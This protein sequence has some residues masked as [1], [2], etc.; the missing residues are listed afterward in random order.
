MTSPLFE[1]VPNFS[2]GRDLDSISALESALASVP[3]IAMLDRTSDWDHHRTV[4]T[5]AGSAEAVLEA[6]VRA[7]RQAAASIDLNQH[8]GIHPR[9][10]ALDV[11][12]FI[13]LEGVTLEDCA[14]LAHRAGKRIWEEIGV[15]VYFYGAAALRPERS[16]LENVRRGQFERLRQAGLSDVT[17]APDVGGPTLHPT[18]GAVIAGA[19]K[20]LVAFNVNLASQ[21]I[22]VA[23]AI[24]KRI[25]SSNGGFPYVKALGLRLESRDL[26]QVSMNLT[27]FEVTPLD[28]VYSEVERLAA[29]YGVEIAES[30][31]IGL[32][33][34]KAVQRDFTRRFK[35]PESSRDKTI[36][37]RLG[38]AALQR[39]ASPPLL[40]GAE[41][42]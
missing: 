2:E 3:G 40:E 32:L 29:E 16:L 7:S 15:P 37:E 17:K 12:P 22:D 20:I 35:L 11:L 4:I 6:A 31:L 18:A 39:T 24:A 5:F 14:A 8:V 23:K 26:I 27:D 38:R 36:E 33:P 21:S 19:R 25:R 42:K 41:S 9:L 28:T 10:G 1:C 13:P 34:E 30:E